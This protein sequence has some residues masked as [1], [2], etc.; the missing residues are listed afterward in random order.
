[1]TET[2]VVDCKSRKILILSWNWKAWLRS[3]AF[4][5]GNVNLVFRHGLWLRCVKIVGQK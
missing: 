1:M 5:M 4:N 2:D 3:Q